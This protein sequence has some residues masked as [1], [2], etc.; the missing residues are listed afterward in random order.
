MS[1]MEGKKEVF[2]VLGLTPADAAHPGIA[3]AVARSGGI[4]LLDLEFCRDGGQALSNFRR[5]LDAT[6]ARVGLRLTAGSVELAGRLLALVS[7]GRAITLIFAG[8]AETQAR[9][10][11]SL[12]PS[13]SFQILADLEGVRRTGISQVK[14]RQTALT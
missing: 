13:T 4:G 8:S 7:E 5:L 14:F 6:E 9:S 11:F 1:N 2:D 12:C 3:V 10:Y